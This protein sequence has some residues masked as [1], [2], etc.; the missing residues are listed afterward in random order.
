MRIWVALMAAVLGLSLS[1]YAGEDAKAEQAKAV[2]KRIGGMEVIALLDGVGIND[3]STDIL[4][5]AGKEDLER[6]AQP[7]G[8][9]TSINAF[10]V[11]IGGKTVLFDTGMPIAQS[12]GIVPA[13]AEADLGPD[14]IDAV[15]I[16]HFH[17]DHVGGLMHR[18]QPVYPRAELY[19]PRVEVNKWSDAGT[20]FLLAYNVRTNAFEDRKE[21]LPGV[22]AMAAYGHTP[23]HTVFLL[24]SDGGKLLIAGD[25]IHLPGVQLA[26]PDVAVTYDTDP[27]KAVASRKR[28]FE[29]AA[30]KKLPIAAMHIPFPGIGTLAKDGKGYAFTEMK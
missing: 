5:G 7:D 8:L 23:G 22:T 3:G 16:T 6:A 20:D 4:V 9:K 30:D 15:V 13:L 11:K 21:I 28:V 29:M 12:G 19:V 26:N 2:S 14:D 27:V 25:L 24:E 18:G 10:V 1:V 17:Y